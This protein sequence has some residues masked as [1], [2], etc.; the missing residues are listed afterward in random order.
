MY[1]DKVM[2]LSVHKKY[3]DLTLKDEKEVEIR[4]KEPAK[5]SPHKFIYETKAD[6]GRG[7]IVA[8]IYV[9]KYEMRFIEFYN[10][11]YKLTRI[12]KSKD[13]IFKDKLIE[14]KIPYGLKDELVE[15]L[16]Q[17]YSKYGLTVEELHKYAGNEKWNKYYCWHIE[18][19]KELDREYDISEFF[20]KGTCQLDQCVPRCPFL[21]KYYFEDGTEYDCVANGIKPMTRPPQSYVYVE[22]VPE[23]LRYLLD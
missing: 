13:S 1:N 3:V 16:I 23:S 7:K 15:N 19:K 17:D 21:E 11:E 18:D 9:P 6:G 10:N 22:S 8:Y 14:H 4:K 20:I 2:V 5:A 12:E